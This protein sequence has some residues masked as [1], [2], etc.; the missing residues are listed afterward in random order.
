MKPEDKDP[1]S[2]ENET[3]PVTEATPTKTPL[4]GLIASLKE[5]AAEKVG[6]SERPIQPVTTTTSSASWKT[7]NQPNGDRRLRSVT[8][9]KWRQILFDSLSHAASGLCS[10]VDEIFGLVDDLGKTRD[11]GLFRTKA[12]MALPT[13]AYFEARVRKCV[14]EMT[15]AREQLEVMLNQSSE[16]VGT[17]VMVEK[18]T[19]P[20]Q[21]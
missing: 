8:V 7:N 16:P 6:A 5:R 20:S 19:P 18:T 1:N 12:K 15:S 13:I 10:E 9:L 21:Q 11:E 4:S 2:I 3:A 14:K 17:G